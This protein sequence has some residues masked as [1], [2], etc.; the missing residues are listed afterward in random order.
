MNKRLCCYIPNQERLDKH[1]QSLAE[2]QIWMGYNPSPDDYTESCAEHL[3]DMLDDSA[4]FE[5]LRISY[6]YHGG[7]PDDSV[8]RVAPVAEGSTPK[9]AKDF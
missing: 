5:V 3:K 4:R 1:C 7:K 9:A 6:D 8:N 2:Y